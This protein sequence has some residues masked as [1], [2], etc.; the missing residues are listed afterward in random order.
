MKKRMFCTIAAGLLMAA[1]APAQSPAQSSPLPRTYAFTAT[2]DM[3]GP[4]TLT[5]SRSGSMEL[6]EVAGASGGLHLRV[7]YDFQAHRIYTTDLDA[8]RCTTQEYSSAYAPVLWDPIGGGEEQAL[9]TRSLPTIRR[10]PVNGI[11]ARLVEAALPEGQG[12]WKSWLD[13]KFGFP[14]KQAVVLGSGPERPLFEMR[15]ISYAP[16]A[17]SLFTAPAQCT[18]IGGVSNANGGSAEMNVEAT[19]QGQAALGGATA[20]KQAP[21]AGDPN[22]LAGKWDF[23]GKDGA[24]TQWHGTL[25]VEKLEPNSFDPA[26]Y[27]NVCDLNLS[28]ANSGKGVSNACLY[29]PQTKTFSLAGGEDSHQ[30]SFTAVLSPDGASLTQGRWV[31]GDSASGAWSATRNSGAQPKR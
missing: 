13:E 27:S 14:V 23:A 18:R 28:S 15:K 3:S 17:A 21:P 20:E 19:A 11:A 5:V 7:L 26:K 6:V 8:G 31:E 25:T 2:S 9:A 24:G 1:Q 16:P 10:E 12:K 29:D 22:R 4:M 30:Y